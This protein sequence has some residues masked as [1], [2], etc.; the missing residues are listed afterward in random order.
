MVFIRFTRYIFGDITHIADRSCPRRSA[1]TSRELSHP[2]PMAASR[3]PRA[4]RSK[5]NSAATRFIIDGIHFACP[6][7]PP[8]NA[9][10]PRL[11]G[12]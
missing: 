2:L 8:K 11:E 9:D 1:R 5:L 12:A 3:A 7:R 4:L 6:Y 10:D